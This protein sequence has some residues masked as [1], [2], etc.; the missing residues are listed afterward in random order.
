MEDNEKTFIS[1]LSVIFA[2]FL[3]VLLTLGAAICCFAIVSAAVVGC[4]GL[5]RYV[6]NLVF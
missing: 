6:F 2:R 4:F 5:A 1:E 3:V